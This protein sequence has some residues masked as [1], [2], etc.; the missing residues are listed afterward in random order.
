MM[1]VQMKIIPGR[2][3]KNSPHWH[4]GRRPTDTPNNG[5]PPQNSLGC[6]RNHCS[7]AV[8]MSRNSATTTLC[9][10]CT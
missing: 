9:R 2:R 1:L 6:H 3:F 10:V 7:L 5:L 4:W 8:L